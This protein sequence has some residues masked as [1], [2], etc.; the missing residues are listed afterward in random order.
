MSRELDRLGGDWA[1]LD[2]RE[3]V[4]SIPRVRTE[5]AAQPL[6]P[7]TWGRPPH[8]LHQ[9]AENLRLPGP[10]RRPAQPGAAL[11]AL[12]P[13]S[14]G[15]VPAVRGHLPPAKP[16][17][18]GRGQK[19]SAPEPGPPARTAAVGA[20]VRPLPAARPRSVLSRTGCSRRFPFPGRPP[21]GTPR[22]GRAAGGGAKRGAKDRRRTPAGGRP[23][24]PAACG[25]RPP[26]R[27]A[28]F[29]PPCARR[30]C[31][32]GD[33]LGARSAALERECG[34]LQTLAELLGH[35]Q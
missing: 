34:R 23:G 3:G 14:G 15:R 6:R 26:R 24:G 8:H 13:A 25:S 16:A 12:R 18:G 19:L 11:A 22:P 28:L 5:S 2:S 1:Q 10:R 7:W 35:Y 27:R 17:D 31:G 4:E 20:A 29:P 21:C 9:R 33:A 30:S 32:N